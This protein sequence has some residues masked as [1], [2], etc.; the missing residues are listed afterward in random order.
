MNTKLVESLVQV[1][2]SLSEEEKKLLEE[3][4]KPQSDWEKQRNR[5]IAR[6]KKIYARRGGKP[7]KPSVTEIIHQM[8][9]E[10]DEQLMQACCPQDERPR[11]D[12]RRKGTREKD[13]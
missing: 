6:A 2:N 3:K 8:R 11:A 10:R 4:L 5:I 13:K 7:F 9:E 1:I 12:E